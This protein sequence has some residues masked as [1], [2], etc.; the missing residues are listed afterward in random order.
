MRVWVPADSRMCC[1][2]CGAG[3]TLWVDEAVPALRLQY[4]AG[5]GFGRPLIRGSRAATEEEAPEEQQEDEG[6][7]GEQA[8]RHGVA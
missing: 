4:D 5:M 1:R 3:M 7:D 2:T 8:Q 6:H